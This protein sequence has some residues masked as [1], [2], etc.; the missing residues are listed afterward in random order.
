MESI[1]EVSDEMD[2]TQIG[3][4]NPTPM[5]GG[6]FFTKFKVGDKVRIQRIKHI[7]EKQ[8]YNWTHEVFTIDKI[9]N[10]SK[11][12]F[13]GDRSTIDKTIFNINY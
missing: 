7:F 4:E 11:T 8:G 10:I 13:L 6:S 9:L 2:F 1:I 3:L 5:Q 12:E